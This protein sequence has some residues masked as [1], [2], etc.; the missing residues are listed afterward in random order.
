[1]ETLKKVGKAL[2]FPHVA[3][4]I[5]LVPIS[6]SWLAVV[7]LMLGSQHIVSCVGYAVSAYTLTVIS[8][9][10]PYFIKLCK[11]IKKENKY[12]VRLSSDVI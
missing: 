4:M 2:L 9:R 11:R 6:A 10:V 7:F 5:L 3:I 1:M 12:I 8:V